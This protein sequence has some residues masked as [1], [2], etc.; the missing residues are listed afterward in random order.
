MRLAVDV[1]G[2]DQGPEELLHGLKLGLEADP[3]IR[4]LFAVGPAAELKSLAAKI[5]LDDPRLHFHQASEVLTMEDKPVQGLR[6]KKDCSLLRAVELVKDGQADAVISSG[7]T[8][9][10]VAASTIRLRTLEGVA[11]PTIACILPSKT[12]AWVLVD[13]GANPECQPADLL[14]FAVMGAAYSRAMLNVASPRVGVLSNGSELTKGTELTRTTVDLLG[15]TSLNCL[16]Y[17]EGYDL[18]NDGVDVVVCDGFVGNI[19]LK[20]SEGLGRAFGHLLKSELTANPFR[21]LGALLAKRGLMS[22][23]ERMNPDTY[24]GAPLLGLNGNV[25]K[26]HGSA[27]RT[28]LMHAIRQSSRLVSRHL[29]DTI[30]REIA[31]ATAATASPAGVAVEAGP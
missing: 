4:A 26:I 11:R 18:Y 19:V 3:E 10:I 29:N 31:A 14:Q 28:A 12:Q 13:G 25:I 5:G 8:G 22:L 24:G 2:G 15:K 1:M 6:K 21:K 7:N 27:N 20:T 16:G 17:C 30:V 9:G 23:K